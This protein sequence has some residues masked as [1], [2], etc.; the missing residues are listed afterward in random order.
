MLRGRDRATRRLLGA[1]VVAGADHGGHG[2]RAEEVNQ[3]RAATDGCRLHGGH[4]PEPEVVQLEGCAGR[5]GPVLIASL[6]HVLGDRHL[7]ESALGGDC[8]GIPHLDQQRLQEVGQP[9]ALRIRVDQREEH[10]LRGHDHPFG[11]GPDVHRQ[12]AAM[13]FQDVLPA[14]AVEHAWIV[15]HSIAKM[16][17]VDLCGFIN[18]LLGHHLA[19]EVALHKVLE[20]EED[21]LVPSR[22]VTA[23]ALKIA[24]DILRSWRVLLPVTDFVAV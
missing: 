4:A 19:Q 3:V 17:R 24:V 16:L 12:P 9:E 2:V 7:L 1:V 10:S 18:L 11:H 22:V 15:I 6:L 23:A 21:H 8:H 14:L 13:F 5:Y 20:A